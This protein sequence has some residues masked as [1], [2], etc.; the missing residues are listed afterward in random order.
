MAKQRNFLLGN[1][2]RL[3][4]PV[5]VS[6][7]VEPQPPPYDLNQAKT[8][9][10]S[11]FASAVTQ[12]E[13]L[14]EIACP[15]GY[16]VGL[17][18][19]HPEYTAK[20]Y[21]PGDLLR[22]ARMEAIGSRPARV[23]PEKWKKK[24]DPEESPTTELFVAARREDFVSF[25]KGIPTL[26]DSNRSSRDL[27]KVEAFRAPGPSDRVQRLRRRIAEPLLEVVLHTTGMPHP[28]QI[29]DA[30]E[31]YAQSLDLAP[32]LD[33]RFEV[34]GL[35]FLPIRAERTLIN[36]LSQFSFLRTI[37]EM[38]QL[39]PL[40]PI[41]RTNARTKPFPVELPAT[42]PVDKQLRAAVFDGGVSEALSATE[43]V[44]AYEPEGI[45][46]AV[47]NFV[48]HGTG[49]TSATL[50]GPLQ[51]GTLLV[52]PYGVVDHYRVLDDE[53]SDDAHELYVALAHIRD[54]LQSRKYSFINLSIGP[55]LPIEDYDV[56][57]WTAVLDSLLSDGEALTTIA[58]GNEGEKD[59]ESGNAR[60]QVP[61]DSVNSLAVG[62]ATSRGED[63][64]RAPYSCIGPGRSPGL[65]KPEVVAFG[66]C[67][68]EPFYVLDDTAS[69]ATP[70]AGT[71]LASPYTLH[72]GMG[73]RAHFGASLS[74]LAIKSLL[75]HCSEPDED[76]PVHEIGWGRVPQDLEAI[77]V[78]PEGEARIVYQGELTPGQYLRTPVPLPSGKLEGMVTLTAT[79]CFAC[80][81][82]PHDPSNYTRGGLDVT[83]RP[84]AQKFDEDAVH[85]RSSSFF[86]RTD[87]DTE[88]ELRIDAPKWG[89]T[90]HRRRRFQPKTLKDPVF[91]VHYQVRESG[92]PTAGDKIRYALVITLRAPKTKNLYDKIVQRYQTQLEPMQ[93]IIEVP[94]RLQD[95]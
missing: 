27:F 59:H 82:D 30:F 53:S 21:F 31:A 48:D 57:S 1:G 32:E 35:C 63:W 33:R 3:T 67:S 73:V 64:T 71:S 78:C 91:D 42:E 60:V 23:K 79:F 17:I 6:K 45:G 4:S 81:T 62:A 11:Q 77:V 7:A 85:P 12:F 38:P 66:G 39:R 9:L 8:R 94:V 68:K 83:F 49:V 40:N 89:T 19:L 87:Y 56:H 61:S 50:F 44:Q 52:Q 37:R 28:S 69:I 34:G 43:F 5:T 29:L 58:V 25:S 54:V 18:T 72:M 15:D 41:I 88:K 93:P 26:T 70:D 22:E 36:D 46:N 16:T 76:I 10:T 13:R 75:V 24:R 14:P 95:S 51:K 55:A 80:E 86:R 65:I 92:K 20:S 84:H 47:D 74:A 2:H 90:L